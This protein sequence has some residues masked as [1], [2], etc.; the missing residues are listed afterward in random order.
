MEKRTKSSKGCECRKRLT[1]TD[2]H[3]HDIAIRW[4][5]HICRITSIIAASLSFCGKDS[6]PE[7]PYCSRTLT[8]RSANGAAGH[9][10]KV[11]PLAEIINKRHDPT[12]SCRLSLCDS[13]LPV[14]PSHGHFAL[15]TSITRSESGKEQQ[16]WK[17]PN[18]A[19]AS[20]RRSSAGG[21]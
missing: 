10:V 9:P 8:A 5:Q 13:G 18:C 3:R 12:R 14:K 17:Q 16:G 19:S 6:P 7:R 20:L 15:G 21:T 1:N 11:F 2:I 4:I